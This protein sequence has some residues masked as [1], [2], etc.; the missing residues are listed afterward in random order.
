MPQ[1]V[2]FRYRLEG[3]DRD[4]QDPGNR[5]QA[6]YTDLRPGQYRF[7]VMASNNDGVWNTTGATL[8]F[9]I[10]PAFYQTI[11]SRILLGMAA[12]VLMWVLYSIRVRQ[13]TANIKGRLGERLHE[14]ERI[15][16][17]LHD[18][19]LQDFHAV[20]LHL[21]AASAHLGKDDPT[22]K[23]FEQGLDYADE[24]LVQ[25]RDRI[26][27]LRSDTNSEDELAE[28]LA[29]YGKGLAEARTL[30]FSMKVTGAESELDPIVRDEVFRIGREALGNAFKH[31]NGSEV[32]AEILYDPGAIKMRIRDNGIGID[33][34]VLLHGRPGHWGLSGMHERA[35]RI[36]ATLSIWSRPTE[37]TELELVLPVHSSGERESKWLRWKWR[38]RTSN[39]G[40]SQ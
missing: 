30:S 18:T 4:W 25:G 23:A 24:V 9:F 14:R 2:Q 20:I 40:G 26:Y 32:A 16:R 33:P 17:E 38:K 7:Q 6:F 11:W 1:K 5:R 19:L 28:S 39:D 8:D 35:D 36:G 21:Q 34:E 22:R 3:R 31:S 15:A 10:L 29:R 13:V 12:V 27:D 37:G